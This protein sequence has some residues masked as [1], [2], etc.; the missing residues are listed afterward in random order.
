MLKTTGAKIELFT[1][2]DIVLMTE[3]GIR[4]SLTQAIKKYAVANNKYLDTYD[5]TKD[6]TYLQH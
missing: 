1:D 4:G 5:K 2:I 6:S 3:K